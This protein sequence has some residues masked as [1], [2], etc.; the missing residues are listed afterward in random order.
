MLAP[1]LILK[2]L[3]ELGPRSLLYYLAYQLGLRTGYYRWR[4]PP[5]ST[6]SPGVS[7]DPEHLIPRRGVVPL[8]A[9]DDLTAV[10][11][12]EGVRQILFQAD[13]VVNGSVRLF[14]GPPLPMD[15]HPPQP[16]RHW[17]EYEKNQAKTLDRDIRW[18]W[19]IGRLGWV[20]LLGR[21][22]HLRR[23]EH[24]SESF[25]Q[26]IE[27]FFAA[28]PIHLGPQWV[29]AQEIAL[30]LIALA[31]AAEVFAD[32]PYTTQERKRWLGRML[33]AHAYR[34]PLTL[35]YALAQNNNHLLVEAAGLFTAGL[36]LDQH[37]H[38]KR[39]RKLGGRL[40]QRGLRTQI[41]PD[42]TYTQH[43]T[44]YHR[45]MLQSALWMY[46]LTR[47]NLGNESPV[48]SSPALQRLGAATC[49]L[50]ALLDAES[51]RVP[52]LGANDGAYIL[53]MTLCPQEDYRPVLQSASR[54]FLHR[55]ALPPGPWDEMPLWFG[56]ARPEG[57]EPKIANE[58]AL[59]PPRALQA[60]PHVL[61]SSDT[62]AYLRVARFRSRPSH[63]D[64]LHVDLWW[65]G[66]NLAQDAG[67]YLYN[68]PP[69]WDNSLSR[70][71]VHNTITLDRC[72]QMQRAGR[73]LWLD[74]AN[75]EVVSYECDEARCW[76]RIVARHHGYRRLDAMH[77]RTLE[78]HSKIW[79]VT[80]RVV[81]T[82]GHRN[83]R[84][85]YH[86]R[87]HWLLPDW[88]WQVEEEQ[89]MNCVL[90]LKSPLGWITLALQVQLENKMG[91][92]GS[93]LCIER[94]GRLI[95]G[96]GEAHPTHGWIS[97][98][99]GYKTPALSVSLAV[100]SV[101]PVTLISEWRLP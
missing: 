8:P 16:L 46:M 78:H 77:W 1:S 35:P 31:F 48:L 57:V 76:E 72:D 82:K 2:A 90:R 92:L 29:S 33:A 54:A 94:G 37:P 52:N 55:D 91:H 28:N 88:E 53:P 38:A 9:L 12:E 62:H 22:Y 19:E 100:S 58:R 80:D 43:S 56:L 39:W 24:Y 14:G 7:D 93:V 64:L 15:F 66:M 10:L 27:A 49:W 41:A 86:I 87:L 5:H 97:P 32:S 81:A 50:L 3:V 25:W 84:R 89:S 75:A 45:L 63:A 59:R 74:W 40:F 36:V 23:E 4:T 99:Y 79:Q 65:R 61:R 13:E 73:F 71:E 34:L 30:R 26:L 47:Q 83:A 101:L 18:V 96:Q 85:P 67:S 44:N 60:T 20:Y 68:A 21:A 95:Y 70:T 17:T 6:A 11:R 42:G 98:T 69:P 51:G